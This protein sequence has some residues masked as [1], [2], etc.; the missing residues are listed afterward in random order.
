MDQIEYMVALTGDLY[1]DLPTE[2]G[3]HKRRLLHEE[4]YAEAVKILQDQKAG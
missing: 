3:T 4:T 1:Y 2:P